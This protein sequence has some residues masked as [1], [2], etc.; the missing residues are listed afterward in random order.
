MSDEERAGLRELVEGAPN[1]GPG[2]HGGN[3]RATE[4]PEMAANAGAVEVTETAN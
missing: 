4:R 3:T 2:Q 1:H